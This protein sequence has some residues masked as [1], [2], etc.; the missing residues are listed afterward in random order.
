M[1][2]HYF[3]IHSKRHVCYTPMI[4]G[5]CFLLC[6]L[7]GFNAPLCSGGGDFMLRRFRN[8]AQVLDVTLCTS[9]VPH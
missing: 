5:S 8:I 2:R 9:W 6:L 4:A 3:R 1:A 7:P